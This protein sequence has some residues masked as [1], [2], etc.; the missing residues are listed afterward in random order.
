[1][2]G[3]DNINK[4]ELFKIGID[5]RAG[6]YPNDTWESLNRKYNCPFPTGEAFRSYV[7]KRLKKEDN[8]PL[9]DKQIHRDLN[10]KDLES[11]YKT[12]LEINKDGTQTSDKLIKMSEEEAKDINFLLNAHGFDPKSWE[13]VSARNNIWNVYS[14]V[15]GVQVLYSSKIV[16]KPRVDSISIEEIKEHFEEFSKNYQS[17]IHKPSNYS[18]DGKMLEVNIADT[19]LGKLCWIGE[20]GES[21]DY[22]I[23]RERFLNVIN[24]I[25]T[26][27]KHYSFEK[28]LFIWSQDFFHFDTIDNTTTHGTKQDTDMRWQKLFLKGIEMLIEG[29]DLLSQLAPVET[30]YIGANHD[31]TTSYYAINYLYAWYRN[32]QNITVDISPRSRKYYEFGKCLIGFA[33]GDTEKKRIAGLM[34]TEAREAWGRTLWHEIHLGHLHSEQT[35]EE[36][37]IIIRNISSITSTDNWHYESGYIG[38]VKKA[39]S[40][41]WDREYG[42]TDILHSVVI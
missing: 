29:I 7:K 6:L 20:T 8:L 18:I 37:N 34:P 23:A 3:S 9:S 12:T 1:M 10:D 24:D 22:K 11:K 14:K 21:Y 15:H 26:R 39:Q 25:I 19:H 35:R 31:K 42:L 33:H 2:F 4:D 28:I 32:N 27:T 40:F 16:V 13:L 30:F 5:F 38:A 41:V 36:N 17:P